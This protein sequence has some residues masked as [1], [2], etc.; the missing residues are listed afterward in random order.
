MTGHSPLKPLIWVGSTRRE[1]RTFPEVVQARMGYALYIAQRGDK[2]RD[3]KPLRGFRSAAVVEMVADYQGDAFRCVYTV[4]Y[5]NAIY[6]LH[7]FQKKAKRG[8]GTPKPDLDL[9]ERRLRE[10]ERHA[11]KGQ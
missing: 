7:A 6:V 5:A 4:R 10:A 2:H 9:I 8:I 1:F 3:A 11:Q